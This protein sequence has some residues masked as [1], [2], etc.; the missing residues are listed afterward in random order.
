MTDQPIISIDS[1][2]Q[3]NKMYGFETFHPM[4]SVV[5]IADAAPDHRPNHI[6]LRY[7]LYALWLTTTRRAPSLA[8]PQGRWC[9]ST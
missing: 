3:Y 4:V 6:T 9:A 8:S 7:G 2:D 5:D 1:I